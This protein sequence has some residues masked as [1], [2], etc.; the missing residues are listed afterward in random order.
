MTGKASGRMYRDDDRIKHFY[1]S[2]EEADSAGLDEDQR[3]VEVR[4]DDASCTTVD[5]IVTAGLHLEMMD[6]DRCWMNVNGLHVWFVARRV[7]GSRRLRLAV[8]C[9][10]DTCTPVVVEKG[11]TE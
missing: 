5:E 11:I 6:E 4:Y 9:Y 3:Y 7:K 8:T 2:D 1:A 10:A